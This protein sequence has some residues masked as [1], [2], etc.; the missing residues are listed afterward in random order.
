MHRYLIL[1]LTLLILTIVPVSGEVI[2]YWPGEDSIGTSDI[3]DITNAPGESLVFATTNGISIFNDGNWE[4]LHSKARDR[5]GY[6]EG[7]PLNDYVLDAEY[8]I[9]GNLWLGYSDGIQIYDGYTKPRTMRY[10]ERTLIIYSINDL[11]ARSDEMW[12]ATGNSG[13]YCYSKGEWKWFQPYTDKSP[14]ANRIVSMAVDYS[15]GA[16]V[17]AS[18]NEG[19]YILNVTSDNPGFDEIISHKISK[20]MQ[21]VRSDPS[22]GVYFFN[23]TDIVHYNEISGAVNILNVTDLSEDVHNI[24]DVYSTKDGKYIIG[25]NYGLYAWKEG[26]ILKHLSRK[27]LKENNIKKVFVDADGRWWFVNKIL[28]GYYYEKEFEPLVSI[29]FQYFDSLNF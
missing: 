26:I 24:N 23:E 1:L 16:L 8:D 4:I 15:T 9:Y 6:L 28:T 21:N 7:I 22:G 13:V 29:E 25:T 2:L 19:Q 14:G 18:D 11:Q 10:P 12:V 20:D 5:R 3:K 17:L 27:D